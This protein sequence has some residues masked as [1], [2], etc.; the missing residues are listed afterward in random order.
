ML[1]YVNQSACMILYLLALALAFI[2]SPVA[3]QTITVAKPFA[4]SNGDGRI[5]FGTA[6]KRTYGVPYVILR[7]Q[8][9]DGWVYCGP[10]G[11]DAPAAAQVAQAS[12]AYAV[13][14]PRITKATIAGGS[15]Q[16]APRRSDI[17]AARVMDGYPFKNP[18]GENNVAIR[19]VKFDG[20]RSFLVNI[21]QKGWPADAGTIKGLTIERVEAT[22]DKYCVMIRR[23]SS[24]IT[25]R[26]FRFTGAAPR[27]DST[28][29]AGI[30]LDSTA[31]DVL[32]ERGYVAGFHGLAPGKKY[33]Q[34]DGISTERGNVNVTIRNVT[35]E[36]VGDGCFDLKSSATRLDN[37]TATNAGHYSYRL[38]A[39]GTAG[40]LVSINPGIG[41]V[42]AASLSTD[43]TIDKLV[44]VG[45]GPLVV[46]DKPGGKVTI[47]ACDLS[48][49]TG[50]E[51][52]KDK[53]AVTFGAGC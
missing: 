40:T 2:A 31:H 44:A 51:K 43:W 1:G 47:R 38:W 5:D 15:S 28:I 11:C 34:G 3:A 48:R 10:K 7:G 29:P 41:H 23:A 13:Q 52:V 4:D 35:C 9:P 21:W 30:A 17:H 45:G 36:N 26:D 18:A 37:L 49:W 53:G 39:Q 42:Q 27:T 20:S 12:P 8:T 33:D 24:D 6:N 46:F 32:I 50:T 16:A 22:C 19:D 25:I 14:A